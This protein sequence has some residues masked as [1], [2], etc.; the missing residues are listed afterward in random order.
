MDNFP[1]LSMLT[2]LPAI[3]GF[4]LAFVEGDRE[5]KGGALATS[6]AVLAIAVGMAFQFVPP[7]G[8]EL[9]FVED[10]VWVASLNIHYRMG[11]DGIAL[12]ML[13]L[14]AL[15][16][17]MAILCSWDAIQH[18][19]KGFFLSLLFLETGKMGVFAASD[20]FLFYVFWE[21]M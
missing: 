2:F 3:G 19:A 15:L 11:I 18:R 5:V 4:A 12:T 14:T 8:G 13:L 17:P 9:A 1:Y 21:V 7:T 20:L 10:H 6:I 16:T